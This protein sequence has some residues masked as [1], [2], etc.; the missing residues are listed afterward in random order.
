MNYTDFFT[1]NDFSTATDSENIQLAVDKASAD[2]LGRVVIPRM[3]RR[4]ACQP[5]PVGDQPHLCPRG[6]PEQSGF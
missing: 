2:R 1:P 5:A 6:S 3:N 4:T